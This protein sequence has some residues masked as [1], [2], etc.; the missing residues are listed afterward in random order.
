M[1]MVKRKTVKTLGDSLKK[2]AKHHAAL[3][4]C[5]SAAAKGGKTREKGGSIPP[6]TAVFP[7]LTEAS[8]KI[9]IVLSSGVK[10]EVKTI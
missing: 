3:G 1:K 9:H 6:S 7:V 2:G 4:A 8:D 5:P 10:N